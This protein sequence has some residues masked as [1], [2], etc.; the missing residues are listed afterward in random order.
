M[1]SGVCQA[2][3]FAYAF[4]TVAYP[5]AGPQARRASLAQFKQR[6][7]VQPAR[8]PTEP[9][10][11]GWEKALAGINAGG[12]SCGVALELMR[13]QEQWWSRSSWSPTRARTPPRAL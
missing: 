7:A 6:G 2:E 5:I 1:I 3:L 13:R 12:T 11:A 9:T 10:L 8:Q 4:D